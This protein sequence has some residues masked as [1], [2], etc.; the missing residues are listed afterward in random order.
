MANLKTIG[1]ILG[2]TMG[3][4]GIAGCVGL[5][6]EAFRTMG[7][8]DKVISGGTPYKKTTTLTGI[9]INAE[10]GSY[11]NTADLSVVIQTENGKKIL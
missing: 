1:S 4:V 5:S 3:F 7:Q 10:I 2:Y 9:P 6:V 8:I 11:W